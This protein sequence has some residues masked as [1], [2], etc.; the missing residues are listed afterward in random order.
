MESAVTPVNVVLK[1]ASTLQA[2]DRFAEPVPLF[3]SSLRVEH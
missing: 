1:I 3:P 2:Q